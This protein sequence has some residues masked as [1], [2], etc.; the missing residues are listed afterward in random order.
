[1]ENQKKIPV[2]AIFDV[3]KTNKKLLL[4]NEQ[5]QVVF[6]RSARFIE[7]LDEDGESCDN[8]DSLRLSIFDSL[9]EVFAHPNFE[10]RAINFATYG[11]SF[12]YLD[13]DGKP[14]TPLYNYLK[15]YPE[16]LK[17]QFY[18][19]YGGEAEFASCTAS[20]VLGSLNSGMQ[21]YRLKMEKPAIFDKVKFALHL[22]QYLSYLISGVAF[23]DKTS[24]G[25]H[26][27][28][29]DF[30][31]ND[32]HYWL[33]EEAVLD[34]MAPIVASDHVS[35]AT[36][37]GS[38]YH[39]GVGL[40]DSSAALIPY[41]ESFKEPFV[42]LSTGTWC[43]TLNPFN[44]QS[45][46]E[47]ELL[48][49]VLCYM[50][51]QGHPVKA[52]RLF[53]GY[54]YE[55]QTKRIAAHFETDVT[56]FRHAVFEPNIVAVLLDRETKGDKQIK[57]EDRNLG[58]YQNVNLAYH[59]LVMDL[60]DQ[61]YHASQLVMKGTE[62]KRIFVDGGFSKNSVFMNLLALAFPEIE[63]YAAH[64]PQATAIGAALAIHHAWNKYPLPNNIIDLKLYTPAKIKEN[65]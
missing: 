24:L 30:N 53:S 61:Q 35:P 36:F 41:L 4:F 14:L 49:D 60:V 11:A 62:A 10:L 33:A 39:V 38:D 48:N 56:I 32:Y 12:V 51:Y 6:E 46:T 28:L 31:R 18:Q 57:F 50:Q 59:R 37:P 26:T 25:C 15:T 63:V 17:N 52:S 1:M 16:D 58:D 42:L 19:K 2:V 45:L 55:Q 47:D 8:L 9:R 27:N 20:P 21:L 44:Q 23:T 13:E 34:K 3:G 22:P 40:H 5:Y 54:V 64:M 7:T 65:S 29:W 43:I